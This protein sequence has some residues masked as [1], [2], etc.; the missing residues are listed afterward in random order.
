MEKRKSTHTNPMQP[1]SHRG[2]CRPAGP[3]TVFQAHLEQMARCAERSTAEICVKSI[4][5]A[6]TKAGRTDLA[7]RLKRIPWA[8]GGMPAAGYAAGILMDGC[9]CK[10]LHASSPA[11]LFTGS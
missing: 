3:R 5:C 6:L 8:R 9:D 2:S 4:R 1:A 11:D 7:Q 10:Q